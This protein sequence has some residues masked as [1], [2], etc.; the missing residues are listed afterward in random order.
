MPDIAQETQDLIDY[1]NGIEH[2]QR[3]MSADAIAENGIAFLTEDEDYWIMNPYDSRKPPRYRHKYIEPYYALGL[4]LKWG[5]NAVNIKRLQEL[6]KMPF[7]EYDAEKWDRALKEM[8]AQD[9][10]HPALGMRK[11]NRPLVINQ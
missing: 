5:F 11:I 1:Y 8:E 2:P 10:P 4:V 7:P 3:E 6:D 9:A